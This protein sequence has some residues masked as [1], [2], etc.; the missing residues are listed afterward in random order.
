M[1]QS[2]G[3]LERD[4]S[5]AD[6]EI[7][8]R[9]AIN[10]LKL[11]PIL[12]EIGVSDNTLTTF[13]CF[14]TRFDGS[15]PAAGSG[16]G[17]GNYSEARVG[18]LFEALEHLITGPEFFDSSSVLVRPIRQLITNEPMPDVSLSLF[19]AS[20]EQEVAC[21]KYENLLTGKSIA[22]PLYISS[23]WYVE[24]SAANIRD[25][26]GDKFNYEDPHR[27]Y[28][29][30]YATNSGSAIGVNLNEATVHALNEVIER[31]ALSLFM[32][33]CFL[34]E[35]EPPTIVDRQTLSD[36]ISGLL[37]YLEKRLDQTIYLV[38]MTTDVQIPA[39]LAYLSKKPHLSYLYGAGASLSPHYAAYRALSELLQKSLFHEHKLSRVDPTSELR[40]LRRYPELY[41]CGIFDLT[42]LIPEAK[43]IA[44]RNGP[45]LN[46][47]ENH[48]VEILKR[49]N[50]AGFSAYCRQV[51][52]LQNGIS[53]VHVIIPGM[54]RFGVIVKAGVPVMP[55][56]RGMRVA[57]TE[58]AV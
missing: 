34:G 15:R 47:T 56:E 58:G 11:S 36:E 57:M 46:G 23:P 13:S 30:R 19:D 40:Y 6:A 4:I 7:R 29:A 25:L 5:L 12:E 18:A 51:C 24:E 2:S 48:R 32:A 43:S 28:I 41:R 31:D 21:G 33:R 26:I 37:S 53:A 8:V 3:L 20:S 50:I 42:S 35:A 16:S 39:Y 1:I 14:L 54:E 9:Y 45:A 44:F 38:D 17:K 22:A 55:G 10:A 49:L 27:H 52:T